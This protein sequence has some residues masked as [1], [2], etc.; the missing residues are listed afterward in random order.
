MNEPIKCSTIFMY[1]LVSLLIFWTNL[2]S[3]ESN[4]CS[5]LASRSP[6]ADVLSQQSQAVQGLIANAA[7]EGV[8]VQLFVS[9]SGQAM[10][11][12]FN[13][14]QLEPMI[15]VPF[16]LEELF[17]GILEWPENYIFQIWD[18]DNYPSAD[19]VNAVMKSSLQIGLPGEVLDLHVE[20]GY[21]NG[22]AG[23]TRSLSHTRAYA[24]HEFG[25]I[26]FHHNLK[27]WGHPL[28]KYWEQNAALMSEGNQLMD[29]YPGL[30]IELMPFLD[31][32]LGPS[33]LSPDTP[34]DVPFQVLKR[35][36]EIESEVKDLMFINRL[37]SKYY[38]MYSELFCDVVALLYSPQADVM[39]SPSNYLNGPLA[40]RSGSI[41]RDFSLNRD[42]LTEF[43]RNEVHNQLN[44]ARYHIWNQYLQ[45]LATTPSGAEFAKRLL[46]AMEVEMNRL[47]DE[48]EVAFTHDIEVLNQRL[49][50]TIDS[51]ST[52]L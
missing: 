15:Q 11:Y 24:A 14:A 2:G 48:G 36:E 32:G 9:K 13:K 38:T 28:A 29:Q 25:H 4:F 1:I 19:M 44:L 30:K 50:N 40:G 26:L 42:S 43:E 27:K 41:N 45:R 17:A 16:V 21:V 39:S 12:Q 3:S 7:N 22:I 49:I 47:I 20:D 5:K 6:S 46:Q 37:Q 10:G 23:Y 18:Q 31:L 33:T 35:A 34:S 52:N 8:Q 51:L